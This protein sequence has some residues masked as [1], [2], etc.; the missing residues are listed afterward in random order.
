MKMSGTQNV[1]PQAGSKECLE[2]RGVNTVGVG[3]TSR[4]LDSG[5][6]QISDLGLTSVAMDQISAPQHGESGETLDLL[7]ETSMDLGD[8]DTEEEARLLGIQQS[9]SDQV[10][11]TMEELKLKK[12]RLSGA[13]LKKRRRERREAAELAN[14]TA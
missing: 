6:G 8:I 2:S 14:Q 4:P 11:K 1:V 7:T 9:D 10:A 3:F 12:K 5:G 13:Q